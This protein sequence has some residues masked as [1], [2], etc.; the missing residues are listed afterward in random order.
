MFVH[1]LDRTK[2]KREPYQQTHSWRKPFHQNRSS[3]L[4]DCCCEL[5]VRLCASAWSSRYT[6]DC[7]RMATCE[8][9]AESGFDGWS[10]FRPS[11][12]AYASSG[13]P[14]SSWWAGCK[15]RGWCSCWSR[16][17]RWS[18][19]WCSVW[20]WW[21]GAVRGRTVPEVAR[22]RKAGSMPRRVEQW[23]R[24]GRAPTDRQE[25]QQSLKVWNTFWLLWNWQTWVMS[26]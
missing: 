11:T 13:T 6:A 12:S 23:W 18:G 1:L 25:N 15:E 14:C 4:I 20:L 2:I 7:W 3:Y 26:Y 5:A 22:S 16:S 8:V 24:S 9:N 10:S 17:G 19:S 21:R